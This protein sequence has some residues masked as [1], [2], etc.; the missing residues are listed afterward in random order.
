VTVQVK[1]KPVLDTATS[2]SLAR[3]MVAVKPD[4]VKRG[5]IQ[6]ATLSLYCDRQVT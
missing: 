6:S 2:S 4:I 5:M 1:A 3:F